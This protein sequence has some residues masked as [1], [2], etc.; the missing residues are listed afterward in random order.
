MT[1]HGRLCWQSVVAALAVVAAAHSQPAAGQN[2]KVIEPRVNEAQA[3]VLGGQVATILR[4]PAAPAGAANK[5]LDD[6][7]KGYLYSSMTSTDPIQLGLLAEKREQLFQRY[8]NAA[9]SP[10][11][12]DYLNT[13]T[14]QAMGAIAKGPY[15]PAVRYNAALII[16]QLDAQPGAKVLPAAT[17]ALLALLEN[18]EFN[19]TPVPTAVKVAALVSLQRHV[20]LGVDAPTGERIGKAAL[21]A[22]NREELPEDA[23]AKAYGWV[24]RQA[25]KV[26]AM[27]HEKGMTPAVLD[28]FTRLISDSKIELD[29]RCA[30]AGLLQPTMFAGAQGLN[31][32]AT[33]QAVGE[34]ARDVLEVEAKDAGEFVDQMIEGGVPAGGGFGGGF[35]GGRGGFGMEG[36]PR[37]GFGMEGGGMDFAMLGQQDQGP[38]YEKRRMIDRTLGIVAAAEA[39]KAAGSDELKARLTEFSAAILAVAEAAAPDN[40]DLE[41]ITPEV[42]QLAK[43]VNRLVGSWAPAK[44]AAEDEAAPAEAP[45]ELPDAAPPEEEAA[46]APADAAGG[47]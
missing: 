44:P 40:A 42:V 22:A 30:I 14:L 41:A 39:L 1:L 28:T 46:A 21:A 11:A 25:A 20:R 31:V 19:K 29:D 3:K 10:A 23:S 45:A 12:R 15:H 38:K 27:Q 32:D 4:D 37:G 9:K 36:G 18:D 13:I 47:A 6:F 8:I 26:L 34:L 24:R 43:D 16:G 17:E 5:Q 33:A 35:E 7:F 2:Y